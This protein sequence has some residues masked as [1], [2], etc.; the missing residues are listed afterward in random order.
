MDEHDV[1]GTTTAGENSQKVPLTF[2]Q[3]FARL[4][5]ERPEAILTPVSFVLII[6]GWELL[7]IIFKIPRIVLPA[8]SAVVRSLYNLVTGGELL[9][10]FGVTLYETL[11]G[12]FLGGVTGLLLGALVSQ[13]HIFEKTIYP[14]IVAFQTLPK[15]AIAPIIII[16]AGY[17]LTSKIIITA[18]IAFFPLLVN[19]IAGLHA[20]EP[21]YTEMLTAFTAS[22]W[23]IFRIVKVP[24]ALPFIFAGLNM[25]GVL[26]VIGA[27]VGEF[28]GAREGLGYL[29]LIR[30]FQLDMPGVFAILIVLSLMGIGMHLIITGV[31]K[32]VVFWSKPEVERIIG[33]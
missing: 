32:R 15:V 5:R 6:G 29:I 13:F 25:A 20:T 3:R 1:L 7:T 22:K 16:W 8:P 19:T 18:M 21:E 12:F 31:Q 17:G 10:H 4:Y 23:Q 28:V 33:A 14:Y 9:R 26:S 11:A 27:I 30:N 24:M 2:R